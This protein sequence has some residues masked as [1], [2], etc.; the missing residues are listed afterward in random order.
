MG[1][2]LSSFDYYNYDD[3]NDLD[4]Y[5]TESSDYSVDEWTEEE[6]EEGEGKGEEEVDQQSLNEDEQV[7]Q[8]TDQE[9]NQD[10][11][12]EDSIMA[13]IVP[14][15]EDSMSQEDG[16]MVDTNMVSL[17]Q[18]NYVPTI[19]HD[20]KYIKKVHSDVDMPNTSAKNTVVQYSIFPETIIPLIDTDDI[21]SNKEY[22]SDDLDDDLEEDFDDDLEEDLDDDLMI[23]SN[24]LLNIQ[25]N[26]EKLMIDV[27]FVSKYMLM[28]I[29]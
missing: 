24:K 19:F 28:Y 12:Q 29:S 26:M 8:E 15:R 3:T 18:R 9:V 16:L 2:I 5:E 6:G 4:T 14:H 7:N 1:G 22:I 21:Q 13:Y 17:C 11:G 27:K 10:E 25:N 20:P 23:L